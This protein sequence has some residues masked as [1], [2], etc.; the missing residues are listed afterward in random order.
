MTLIATVTKCVSIENDIYYTPIERVSRNM[1]IQ[2]QKT[3]RNKMN[4]IQTNCGV[5]SKNQDVN[6][7]I[8]K[9][10]ERALS[11][12]VLLLLML[13]KRFF[14]YLSHLATV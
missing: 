12:A 3:L 14:G 7:K 9:Q 4:C 13:Y 6:S 11:P 10:L 8:V 2:S 1:S 5:K